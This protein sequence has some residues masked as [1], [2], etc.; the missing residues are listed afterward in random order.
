VVTA[1]TGPQCSG[2]PNLE[3]ACTTRQVHDQIDF[4]TVGSSPIAQ[5]STD[6]SQN[7]SVPIPGVAT[8]FRFCQ[9]APALGRINCLAPQNVRDG[10]PIAPTASTETLDPARPWHRI[11][12]G[13]RQPGG[14]VAFA[15]RGD[16][17]NLDYGLPNA[18]VVWDY[19]DDNAFWNG[20]G[21]PASSVIPPPDPGQYAGC[22]TAS[23]GLAGTCLD[24]FLWTHAEASLGATADATTAPG[25]VVVGLHGIDLANHYLKLRPDPLVSRTIGTFLVSG[26]SPFFLW[27][28]LT[29]PSPGDPVEQEIQPLGV[30]LPV[31]AGPSAGQRIGITASGGVDVSSLLSP[32]FAAS[33]ASNA[34][35]WVSAA[36]ASPFV[37]GGIAGVLPPPMAHG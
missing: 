13:S 22:D 1:T 3:L 36:E 35:R 4:E 27:R 28:T 16:D 2:E 33:L 10:V 29:D 30:A 5:A 21:S 34:S 23:G 26:L 12:L 14:G 32:G 25:G 18:P 37:G 11:T 20:S 24:G 7:I 9:Q 17:R 8:S 15:V 19:V 31:V 6:P